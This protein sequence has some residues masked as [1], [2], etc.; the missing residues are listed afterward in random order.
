[1]LCSH[2]ALLMFYV[3]WKLQFSSIWGY[4]A[5][6]WVHLSRW[7]KIQAAV[8]GKIIFPATMNLVQALWPLSVSIS[9][10]QLHL[11]SNLYCLSWV[12][13]HSML[14]VI[15]SH[16][17]ADTDHDCH[18]TLLL[19]ESC[20]VIHLITKPDKFRSLERVSY[21]SWWSEIVRVN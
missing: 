5:C 15:V 17:A 9:C 11:I 4:H 12:Q 21:H 6:P 19:Q 18:P 1:M 2:L 10:Y 20:S 16:Q 3:G 14:M 13:Y 7:N 8:V